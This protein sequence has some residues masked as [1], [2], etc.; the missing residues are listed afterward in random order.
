MKTRSGF[1][2]NSSSSSFIIAIKPS[3]CQ[4]C[5]NG[6]PFYGLLQSLLTRTTDYSD[7]SCAHTVD[8]VL[9]QLEKD[10]AECEN[11]IRKHPEYAG[12]STQNEIDG[13][14]KEMETIREIQ[15]GGEW[16]V[17]KLCISYSDGW[18]SCLME[19]EKKK[20]FLREIRG[21]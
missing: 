21:A 9:I 6:S 4:H 7:D 18:I 5:G 2:S 15:S 16:Q 1:V 8:E 12:G 14:R 13:I 20:G 17:Y 3:V 10:I 19:E 11:F